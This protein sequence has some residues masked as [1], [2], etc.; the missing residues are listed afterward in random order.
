MA[1]RRTVDLLPEIFRTDTNKKFLSATLDQLTQEPNLKRTKG[2]VGRRVGPGVNPLDNYVVEPTAN[3]T[4]YQLEP[5]VVFLK[6]GTEVAEDAITYPGMIDSLALQKANVQRQDRLWSSEYYSWDP[7]CDLDKFTNYSQYY[8]LP[9]GPDS[10]DISTT[11][12]P[13]TDNFDV[14][15]NTMNYTFSGVPGTNPVIT[16]ARGGNYTFTV[17]QPGHKFWIQS[18]PGV[19]GVLPATPNVSS[20]TVLGVINNGEDQGQ[21]EFYVPLNTAQDFYYSLAEIAP[22]DLIAT[23]I[24][25]NQVNNVYV[26]TFLSQF[27]K[28][29]DGVTQLNGRTV[30]FTNK[31]QGTEEGG[32][33]ITTMFDPILDS[34]VPGALGTYDTTTFD[35]TT[36]ITALSQRYGVWKI[37]YVYDEDNNPY[38]SLERIIEVPTLTKFRALYGTQWSSTYWYKDSSGYFVQQP[39]LTAVQNTLYYQD[40][41]NPAIFGQIK[42]VDASQTQPIDVNEI[43]GSKTYTSPNGIVLTNGLKIQFRGPTTPAQ[44]EN[45]EYYVEGVGTGPGINQRIGFINGEAYFGDFHI[46]SGQKITGLSNTTTYQQYIYDTVEESL[47][48]FGVGGPDGSPLP[49]Q[50]IFTTNIGN[51]IKLIPVQ[52][53]V[54]PEQYTKSGLLPYSS[55][56]Y[57]IGGYDASLNAPLIPDYLTINRASQDRNSWSR[58]NRWFHVDVINYSA[59]INGTVAVFDNELRAKRPV[60]EFNANLHLWNYGTEFKQS[61]N[62]V[63]FTQTDALSAVNGQPGYGVNGYTFID[64]TTVI[65]AADKDPA[66]RNKIYRVDFIDP[67]NSGT[68]IIDLVPV[69]NADALIN[70]VVVSLNGLTQQG[71]VFWFNGA[72]WQAAQQKTSVNQ[73]PLFDVYDLNG[74]SFGDRAYY[75]STTFEGTRLFGYAEGGTNI[76]DE[77]IGL[78]LKFLNINNVGD[79]VFSNFFYDDAFIYVKDNISVDTKVGTGFVRQYFDRVSFSNQ[80]GWQTAAAPN[81][82]RQV[83]RFTDTSTSLILDVPVDQA[84]VF[85]PVQVYVDGKFF[86]PGQYSYSVS[87]INTTITF[88]TLPPTGS[89]VEVQAISNVKSSVA[90][91]QVPL[92]LESNSV[93][94]NSSEFTLGTIRSYYNS[95]G[96]NLRNVQGNINGA[97]NTRDLGNLIPYGTEIIQNSSPMM[98]TGVFLRRQQYELFSALNFNSTE[99]VKYKALVCDLSAQGDFINYTPTQVLDAVLQQI[100]SGKTE[101]NPFYWSDMLP[102]GETYTELNYTVSLISTD[103]FTLSRS[104]DFT[105]S[106]FQGLLVYLNGTILTMGYD[107]TVPVDTAA[108]VVSAPL[109]I[110]D[111]ITIREYPTTYGNFVPNT[112]TKMGLY[113]AYKPELYTDLSY[114]TPTDV[115]RGHDGSITVAFGDY[116]DQVLL[117]FENRIFNN[118]KI[119]SPIPLDLSDVMP[120]EFRTTDYTLGEINDILA[121]DFL[122][123]TGFNKLNYSQQT[124]LASDPFT[125]NYSQSGNRLNGEPL[126]GAWRG[127]YNYFYDTISPNTTPWEMLGFSE[128]P[129]WWA[130]RYGPAPYTSGNLVLWGDL[131]RGYVADPV[132]PK[133]IPKYARPGLTSVIPSDSE[134]GLA[135]PLTAVAGNFDTTSF[136]RSWAFGDDGPVEA[137]WRSSSNWPFAVMRLLALTRPAEFFSL[138]VDRDLYKFDDTV[139][140][141]LWNNRARLEAQ[142]IA[143]LYGNGESKAS[144]INWIIDYNQQLGV[145]STTQLETTLNNI[146]A[147]LCWRLAAFSDKNYLKLYTERSTPGGTNTSLLLPDESY[148][149]LLYQNPAFDQ[150][151]FSSVIVQ[152]TDDGWAVFGYSTMSNYFDIFQSKPSGLTTEVI[153]GGSAET[154]P[155]EYTSNVVQVPYGFVFTNRAAVCDFLYSYGKF[156]EAQGMTFDGVENGYVMDWKQMAVEFLYWSNQG[157]S[158]GGIINLNPG[159]AKVNVIKPG[160]VVESLTPTRINNIILNQN[161]QPLPKADLIINRLGND[162]NIVTT[163]SNTIN[164][165]Q[166]RFTAYEH[167]IVLDN[168]SIFADLIYD[169]IT[170]ARQSRILVNGWLSGDWNGTV[171]APGFVLNQDNIQE[172]KSSQKYSKGD[173][174]LFKNEYWSAALIVPA[175]QEFDYA[176]WL[177]S[178]YAQVQ[179]GLLPNAANASDQLALSYSTYNANL[180]QETDLFSYG[181]IGFRPRDYMQALNLDDVS[182]VNLYQQF[183]GSKGTRRSTE[184][185]SFADLGKET[186]QYDIYEHWAVL[187][188]VYGA[189]ANRSYFD[190]R[191]NQ[192]LLPS[193]PSIIQVV[194]PEQVSQADQTV[195]VSDIWQSSYKITSPNILPTTLTTPTDIGLPSAGYVSLSDVDITVFDLVDPTNIATA[196]DS[197]GVGTTVWVAKVNTFDWNVYISQKVSGSVVQVEDN[198][199]GSSIATFDAVH[200][201]K[202]NDIV[203]IKNFSDTINGVYHVLATPTLESITI[204]YTFADNQST[205]VGTGLALTLKTTRVSQPS[206]ILNLD[207]ADQLI[208]GVRVWV[209]D[210]GTGRWATL[211][212]TD[213]F[214]EDATLTPATLYERSLFGASVAQGLFNSSAM[215]GAPGYNPNNLTNAPGGVYTFVRTDQDIYAENSI[216]SINATDT[217]GYGNAM[218]IGD[219]NWGVV[220]ASASNN[221]SGYVTTIYV[222]SSSSFFDQRQLLVPPDQE[223]G[224]AEFGYSVTM[225]QNEQWMFVGAPGKNKVHAYTQVPVQRQL[226]TYVTDGQL[227][228]YNYNDYMSVTPGQPEQISV[229]LDNTLLVYGVNYTVTAT[230]VILASIPV[231]GLELTIT[232]KSG[233][234]LDR[235]IYFDV[236]PTSTSGSGINATFTVNRVR[237]VY[238]TTLQDAGSGYNVADTITISAASVGGGTSPAN[239]LVLTVTDVSPGGTLISFSQSGSGVTNTSVFQL[240]PYLATA[241]NI[242][243]F[244]VRVNGELYRPYLD[245]DF[246]SDSAYQQY[247]LVFNTVPLAGADILVSSDSYFDFVE[248]L[249]VPGLSENARFGHSISCNSNGSIILVGTPNTNSAQGATYVFD[250]NVQQ[251]IITDPTQTNYTTVQSLVTPGYVSATLNGQFLVNTNQNIN[252]T[253]T[254]DISSP[255]NEFVNIGTPLAIGDVLEIETNQITLVEVIVSQQPGDDAAFGY[256]LDQCVNDCS[257]YISSP[258]NSTILPEAGQVE[259]FQN[260]SR[261]YGTITSTVANPVLTAGDYIRLNNQYVECPGTTVKDLATAV[262]SANIPNVAATLLPDLVLVGDGATQSFDIGT[263]YTDAVSYTPVVYIDDVLQTVNVDYV[264]VNDVQI[265]FTTA[266]DYRAVIVVVAGRVTFS[267]INYDASTPLNRLQVL[268]GTGT[269]LDDLGLEIYVWQQT[270]IGPNPQPLSHFGQG[271][272][273]SNNTTTL[274]VGAPNG[275]MVSPTTFDHGTTYFDSHST[276]FADSTLQSGVVYSFDAL[277]PANP[278]VTNPLK[279]VFGQQF[280]NSSIQPLDQYGTAID[281]TTGTLLIGAP[282]SDL[283]DSALANYGKV[284]QYHNVDQGPAW[285]QIRVQEEV[286]DVALLDTIYMYNAATGGP[287]QYFDYFNPLQGRLLGVVRQNLDYIGAV[288]PAAYNQGPVNNYGQRW[289]QERVGHIWWD[290]SNVRFLDPNQDDVVYASRRWGQPFPGSSIDV[291]QWVVSDV[292]PANYTGPGTPRDID[293]YSMSSS[294]D[295]QGFVTTQYYFWVTG[296]RTVDRSARKTLSVDTLTRYIESPRSSG[297]SYIAP[298]NSSTVAIYNG[299]E[300]ISAQDT[301][302]HIEFDKQA[303]EAEVHV[304]YQLI[305]EGKADGF[306]NPTLYR[307]LIDSLSGVDTAGNAVPDPLLSPSQRYG[308]EFRPRQSMVVDRFLALNNYL[309]QANS[310]LAKYPI[311]EIKKFNILNSF[312]AEPPVSSNAWD[313]RLA[314]IEELSYQDLYEVPVGY[315]YLVATDSTNSGLWTIYQVN[316]TAL[317][318]ERYL[319]LIRVQNYDTRLYWN[320]IDWYSP[321]YNQFTRVNAEVPNRSS[322]DTLT[323]PNGSTVKVTYNSQLKW[324]IYQ[325]VNG[326]WIR[327]GLQDGTIE[328]KSSLWSYSVG[329][330]GFDSEVFDAQYFDQAPVIETRKIIEAI[331]QE[332]FIDELLIERNRLL[333]LMF[334]YIL[335]ELIAPSWL[336]KTSLI[337]VDH[338]IRDL[339]PYQIYRRDN[340]DFVL[341]YINEVK[342]Y[343]VQIREFN[344]KYQGQDIFQGSLTDFD[345]PAYYDTASG[346]FISPVL[347]NTGTVSSTSSRPST[348]PIWQTFPWNQWYQN[349][350]LTINDVTI[351][352]AGSGYTVPPTVVVTGDCVSPAVMTAQINS[353]GKLIGII[354]VDGG[355]GYSETATITLEG[356]N[357]S[358]AQVV[359]VMGNALVRNLL[360]VIKYDRYQYQA[361]LAQWQPNVTYLQGALVRYGNIVWEANVTNTA[362][363][364]DTGSWTVIPAGELSG[365]DRTMGYYVPTVDQPGLDLGQLI[366]GVDYPGVQV[367]APGFDQNTGYDLGLFDALPYDNIDYG[368]EGQPT[369]DPAILDTIYE[370]YFLDSYLGTRPTDINV[371]G[372][373]FVDTYESHAPE[374]LVPGITYDTLDMRVFT[375]PGAGWQGIGHGSPHASRAVVFDTLVPTLSFADLLD[376][377]FVVEVYNSTTGLALTPTSYDWINY[378]FDLSTGA[379]DGDIIQIQAYGV[380]GGNQLY[381]NSF[382]GNTVNDG[383][384]IPFPAADINEFVIYNGETYLEPQRYTFFP[385]DDYN[386]LLLFTDD[387]TSN[388]RIN[389]VALGFA[390][391]GTTH[392][393]SLPVTQ[394]WVSDGAASTS[395]RADSLIGTNPV[396][397]IV[398]RNGLRARPYEGAKYIGDGTTVTY[399]LPTRGGYSQSLIADNDVSVYVN[400]TA[401]IL[402]VG[403]VVDPYDG[404]NPMTVTITQTPAVDSSI[405]IA[406][407]TQAQY[408]VTGNQLQFRPSQGFLPQVGDV[409]EITTWNDTSEQ[410]IVTQVFVG[411]TTSGTLIG[412]GYDESFYDS[413]AINNSPGTF[414]FSLGIQ[415][416][417]NIFYTGR[418]LSK[419]E[420]LT[421]TLNGKFIFYGQDYTI[422]GSNIVVAGPTINP[423]A[424]LTVMSTTTTVVPAAMAFRIFQDM[425]GLQSTYRI[426]PDTTTKLSQAL[427]QTDLVIYVEDASRCPEPKLEYGYFGLITINGERIAYRQRD[428]ATNTLLGLRRGT[429]GTAIDNHAVDSYVYDITSNNYVPVEYQNYYDRQEFLGDGSTTVFATDSI[430]IDPTLTHAVE[431]LVGGILQNSGYSITAEDPVVVTFATAPLANY[432][433]SI[434]VLRAESWYEPGTST[435]SNGVPLQETQTKAARFFRGV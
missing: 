28:G 267:V 218:D 410:D 215:V 90:F 417:S 216:L 344:L 420:S 248:T 297:I 382:I 45:L 131:E 407:R 132:D 149:I 311:S 94:K 312:E 353:A 324:E 399:E 434:R 25:F 355:D 262:N 46:V 245:Y 111:K 91:Y 72:T 4:N 274:L 415:I 9:A 162:F 361:N 244:T 1:L 337:D 71:T 120:G 212:K 105:S 275:N 386:T 401:L 127:I 304:E 291:Y 52:D 199:N 269:A 261:V 93:N 381:I 360:T 292:S 109:T 136:R 5:G 388:D 231:A 47:L 56:P 364:F 126:L 351:V 268:P 323:L 27:P 432:Q 204:D 389:L 40:S 64:G 369:Y 221:Y 308:I 107:Y 146:D 198:L 208:P 37:N 343:H 281:Y 151:T 141:Y 87:D 372:G 122:S 237:G 342:P 305:P 258:F 325:L 340:Q 88:S 193:D 206:D 83:F 352:N 259:F 397:L 116:R 181:L 256:K 272:S 299:L 285:K 348:D 20:R 377:P 140:Q 14:T 419:P 266:P 379:V 84:S 123:W 183:L 400:N 110:N 2:F 69:L 186:A 179:K 336:M 287:S 157:W 243:A 43:V 211:E 189:N 96:Q 66:V 10:V 85:P 163:S 322:L 284:I 247:D 173:I 194:Q 280:V 150:L 331:N 403:Y 29:I 129:S 57:D 108:I 255:G 402:G 252:G 422:D 63:D 41:E 421:V 209:D 418:D 413:G 190:L 309:T 195:L 82:S 185:F 125:Y 350:L 180:E 239:D 271:L 95:I 139:G 265:N 54:T 145:N 282:G 233:V 114:V 276:V 289:G 103:T 205:E 222:A 392:S 38:M 203:I 338:T 241:T 70:Q 152:V 416:K 394:I 335:S 260:Q 317:L 50:S 148:Q 60:I 368:P 376:Y 246:N 168:R 7:F 156:L 240:D 15:R 294:L 77:V 153:A 431:V 6:D 380:G 365:V 39:L 332:L 167:I 137:A 429:A 290:T 78:S 81:R 30:V 279:F 115:I 101:I 158:S 404:I 295:L 278:T 102:S 362:D 354:I 188:S 201:L 143:P 263:I 23:T 159:A 171:N 318:A 169:P 395:I 226:I 298:L 100:S 238:Y 306:L 166:L 251:F 79:I 117:E 214:I 310:V 197:I 11:V 18:A 409:I 178:D 31:I 227:G 202:V 225:S 374:E 97:N 373:A 230:D 175:S 250:R 55:T 396:N 326:Q 119:R 74:I 359:A 86:D 51:G 155:I 296:I 315:T 426:T 358:G 154:I 301:V 135:D 430:T 220:G 104:Y 99:Y 321:T 433:V 313:K 307:K 270:I 26:S 35:Q 3:R 44:Y 286:V 387:Y 133:I 253:Y 357:G 124:Y 293:S 242:Y 16:L 428:L 366:S 236:V 414:D 356:G 21:V 76:T 330:F 232:R 128:E 370:S 367:S 300:Y 316:A 42:L 160:A 19:D 184:L 249:T 319:T 435:A 112:P 134:G 375:T 33:Q 130:D 425:R 228:S 59:A 49:Q 234:Q 22:V 223:F 398:T 277:P 36:D 329:R 391:S 138:F 68:L 170:G 257:L 67:T 187:R 217:V 92:N 61:V 172:W 347:D 13:L 408:W 264:V 65:F 213:P 314:N 142:N 147:R 254:V 427:S 371:D 106:N 121:V 118:L 424:V 303:T 283:E 423:Q 144:Y 363:D 24:K 334:N 345:L 191:L 34:G 385:L 210:N 349:Y 327:V 58:S 229:V 339:V 48:N 53:M 235:G 383:L 113:P 302:L 346:L 174:V 75:P 32:W 73:A 378:Q 320:Y 411:P 288:N 219:K 182:Q 406:V 224:A 390:A 200:G 80:L 8:W 207:F 89:V 333:M 341:D 412:Q 405:L 393:W 164:Y 384:T 273:I 176:V 12:I 177:K 165:L 328:F 192:A 98:L 196:I 17:N 161:R 62:I